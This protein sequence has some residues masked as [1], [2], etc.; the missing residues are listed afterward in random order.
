MPIYANLK[1]GIAACQQGVFMS[2]QKIIQIIPA[3]PGL[4]AVFNTEEGEI[5][6][7]V[8]CIA[9]VVDEHGDQYVL[10][11]IECDQWFELAE[12]SENFSHM[13]RK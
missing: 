8:E 4:F 2:K 12:E 6:T 5:E 13:V 1:N 11:M 7:A 3:S 10:P 9:L